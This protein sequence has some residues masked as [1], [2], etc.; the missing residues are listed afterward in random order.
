MLLAITAARFSVMAA[1]AIP[2]VLDATIKGSVILLLV[3]IVTA[4][5]RR[6]SAATRYYLWFLGSISLL[7]LPAL[8]TDLPAWRVLPHWPNALFAP[9]GHSFVSDDM[10][11]PIDTLPVPS[12]RSVTNRTLSA[13]IPPTASSL[14]MSTTRLLQSK[15]WARRF[16]WQQWLFLAWLVGMA[17][18][19]SRLLLGSLSLLR[20][21]SRCRNVTADSWLTL[22]GE[23]QRQIGFRRPVSMLTT[24]SR[25]MPMTWG[26]RRTW[27]LVP[28]ESIHWPVEQR[29]AVLLHELSHAVRL[30]CVTQLLAN[31]A[32]ATQW[33]NPLVWFAHRQLQIERERACDDRVIRGGLKAS[34][35]AEQLLQIAS[36]TPLLWR[37]DAAL[38]MARSSGLESRL[39]AILDVKRNRRGMTSARAII[40]SALMAGLAIPLA[41][42]EVGERPAAQDA[43]AATQPIAALPASTQPADNAIPLSGAAELYT[44]ASEAIRVKSPTASNL[45][46]PGYF[47]YSSTW[48][49]M[50]RAS[51]DQNAAV[52]R[53]AHEGRLM[54]D[55]NWPPAPE[56]AVLPN[57]RPVRDYLNIVLNR[58]RAVATVLGD[59][60]LYQHLQG[61]DAGAFDTLGDL[62]WM[63][64]LTRQH[65]RPHYII[66]ALVAAGFDAFA[67]ERLM[68]IA[69]WGSY[70][71][72]VTDTRA[73][74]PAIAQAMIRQL[75]DQQDPDAQARDVNQAD[76]AELEDPKGR[77]RLAEQL[78]RVFAERDF[79]AISLACHL[80]RLDHQQWPQSLDQLVPAYLPRLPV[81]PWGDGKQPFGYAV[82]KAGL[83]DGMD[84]PLVYCRCTSKDGLAYQPD[85]PQYSFYNPAAGSKQLGQFRDIAGWI[86]DHQLPGGPT[87]RPIP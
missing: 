72:D 45:A 55:A 27:I 10:G 12:D 32:F 74:Q 85:E 52:R 50:A 64:H 37:N 73:L 25:S 68:V 63:G 44:R 82:I 17:V 54:K 43:P 53:I 79:V 47:P 22:L 34:T 42:A 31:V 67:C 80:Y 87:T 78:A 62:L 16:T 57:G 5:A 41:C 18:C 15:H 48:T 7:L 66:R 56:G 84:R 71:K 3:M 77:S 4:T 9:E 60:A 13:S 33:Y 75:L 70:T 19:F 21:R 65:A 39:R 40:A 24:P 14:P 69:A 6:R 38:A 30:D 58:M 76:P 59:A 36:A 61:D 2:A 83:P 35:Y 26:I 11:S 46:F 81:D 86:P 8:H 23:V 1:R 51:F 49:E 29:R 20:L 28:S